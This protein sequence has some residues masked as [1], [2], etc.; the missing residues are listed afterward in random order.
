MSDVITRD[1]V[2]NTWKISAAKVS[3]LN[4]KINIA[5][6][7][8]SASSDDMKKLKDERDK[9]VE[10]RD[11]AQ[12]QLAQFGM[13]PNEVKKTRNIL[14]RDSKE[15]HTKS[16]RDSINSFVHAGASGRKYI[17]DATNSD[18]GQITSPVVAPTIPE[19]IIYD[20]S[21]E[22]NSVVDL[23][24]FLTRTPVST[25]SGTAPII[26]R[27]DYSFPTVEELQE[28]PKLGKPEFSNVNWKVKTHRGALAISNESIQDS[29]VDVSDLILTQM[30]EARV[31]TYN[32]SISDV[33]K[34]FNAVEDAN[35][36]NLV[37]VYKYLLNVALDPAYNPVII[38]SQSMYNALDTLKDKNGQ[39]IFHQD[40][41]GKSGANLLGV[42]VFKIG[43]KL[44]GEA[45]ESTAFIGDMSRAVF[46]ADRQQ[47]NLSWQY[48]EVFGQYLAGA[49][50]YDVVSA[51]PNAGFFLNAKL[52][53]NQMYVPKITP[54]QDAVL[55][56][57]ELG[58][59]KQSD[60]KGTDPATH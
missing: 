13:N 37:D 34:K 1:Q 8:P 41:T 32:K 7:D 4:N 6:S 59:N 28:N 11:T 48:N 14:D 60:E 23:S 50:R 31:N 22:V 49:L 5:L 9:T 12:E 36:D 40:V 3:D 43:D 46:F 29:S 26:K 24:T 35:A 25:G 30:G 39:Y 21:K 51:D 42:P 16:I 19:T 45:G 57:P 56:V 18:D 52:P 55:N 2:E 44:L 15:D 10:I 17:N 33:L 20:P 54:T 47:I 58:D 27:A 53:A 38:A